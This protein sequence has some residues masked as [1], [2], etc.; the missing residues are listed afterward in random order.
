MGRRRCRIGMLLTLIVLL[1]ELPIARAW[2]FDDVKEIREACGARLLCATEKGSQQ[3]CEEALSD[4]VKRCKTVLDRIGPAD[5]RKKVKALLEQF[6]G[7]GQKGYDNTPCAKQ[8]DDCVAAFHDDGASLIRYVESYCSGVEELALTMIRDLHSPAPDPD[9]S[10]TGAL[11]RCARAIHLLRSTAQIKSFSPSQRERRDIL[12]ERC[13][14]ALACPLDASACTDLPLCSATIA[15]A[16]CDDIGSCVAW[17]GKRL[18]AWQTQQAMNERNLRESIR[19]REQDSDLATRQRLQDNDLAALQRLQQKLDRDMRVFSD[20][21]MRELYAAHTTVLDKRAKE[22]L[23]AIKDQTSKLQLGFYAVGR[24]LEKIATAIAGGKSPASDVRR[25][26]DPDEPLTKTYPEAHLIEHAVLVLPDPRV[27]RHRRNYEL[28]LRSAITGMGDADYVLDRYYFPWQDYDATPAKADRWAATDQVDDGK[29]GVLVFRNDEWRDSKHVVRGETR[30]RVFY[31]V[32]ETA[33]FGVQREALKNALYRTIDEVIG[34]RIAVAE[35]ECGR[36]DDTTGNPQACRFFRAKQDFVKPPVVAPCEDK[37]S[38]CNT[39]GSSDSRPAI[40]VIGPG[41]SSS[42]S[43]VYAVAKD[44]DNK[45]LPIPVV[46][47]AKLDA[48]VKTEETV[49][50]ELIS[51]DDSQTLEVLGSLRRIVVDW[52]NVS[53]TSTFDALCAFARENSGRLAT[54]RKATNIALRGA[55]VSIAPALEYFRLAASRGSLTGAEQPVVV[56]VSTATTAASNYQINPPVSDKTARVGLYSLAATDKQ[57]LEKI[58]EHFQ[59]ENC[60]SGCART[61]LLYE[62]TSFG[63]GVDITARKIGFPLSMSLPFP[64]N[65]ADLR[66]YARKKD[67]DARRSLDVAS[68]AADDR[69]LPI[70]ESAENGNEYPV[71]ESTL[72]TTTADQQLR[73]LLLQLRQMRVD[74]VIVA[75]TDVRDRLYLFDR[76]G[77]ELPAVRFVDLEADLLLGHPDYVHA[78]RGAL[79]VASAPLTF[80]ARGGKISNDPSRTLPC[81]LEPSGRAS[82]LLSFDSDKQSLLYGVMRCLDK[83]TWQR[84]STLP[85]LYRIG[86]EGPLPVDPFARNEWA[87]ARGGLSAV[88]AA[89]YGIGLLLASV[90]L[91]GIAAFIALS[92]PPFPKPSG[93]LRAPWWHE[94]RINV[95]RMFVAAPVAVILAAIVLLPLFQQ[96]PGISLYFELLV[97]V[98]PNLT[99]VAI[100]AF[101]LCVLVAIGAAITRWRRFGLA[102]IGERWMLGFVAFVIV[103]VVTLAVGACLCSQS[104]GEVCVD[105][106]LALLHFALWLTALIAFVFLVGTMRR[107]QRWTVHVELLVRAGLG[108]RD[109]ADWSAISGPKPRFVRTPIEAGFRPWLYGLHNLSLP[110]ETFE[111][112]LVRLEAGYE[113]GLAARMA[114]RRLLWPSLNAVALCT[115]ALVFACA[116]VVLVAWLYPVPNRGVPLLLGLTIAAFGALT[117][118]SGA[119]AFERSGLLSRLFCGTQAGLQVSVQLMT[120]IT[121]PILLFVLSVVAADQPGVLEWSGGIL[122]L[123]GNGH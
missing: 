98:R 30:L 74:T 5:G 14:G 47:R 108:G 99:T 55:A 93:V 20:A 63:R 77:R 21:S 105:G 54:V 115:L 81:D 94:R 10:S 72:A 52:R 42:I 92:S 75:A 31:V 95:V 89:A 100:A 17:Y 4:D 111:A 66:K 104:S 25:Q 19:K 96:H 12:I 90:L 46:L 107:L 6:P 57:K 80:T 43:S 22:L 67:D 70:E 112:E 58:E 76:V 2:P 69:H 59:Q 61:A 120:F 29:F 102:R 119:I 60:S 117:L 50:T 62:S 48:A 103:V 24:S 65:I 35:F 88:W 113:D 41:S 15:R 86:R 34:S 71:G 53:S 32:A 39:P 123:L 13:K 44:L 37:E 116:G 40:L 26:L 101:L 106:R 9:K 64:P 109:L 51:L 110:D 82:T 8:L 28:A 114:L 45:R 38:V 33:T 68:L 85:H 27:P 49:R 7:S 78:T 91:V 11:G 84:L 122:K 3:A 87:A 56:A 36:G 1:W 23:T 83:K 97:R 16:A 121:A 118:S 18:N 79:M 73:Q